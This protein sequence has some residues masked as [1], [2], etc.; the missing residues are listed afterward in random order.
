MFH[1]C[2]NQVVFTSKMF[3][4][5]FKASLHK[6]FKIFPKVKSKMSVMESPFLLKLEAL[7]VQLY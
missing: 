3:E 4:K 7:G 5:T 1:L 2:G 6:C